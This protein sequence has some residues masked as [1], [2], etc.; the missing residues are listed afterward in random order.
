MEYALRDL[1]FFAAM[2]HYLGYAAYPRE[3][4]HA[5]WKEMLLYQFH[6]ILPGSS[7]TRVYSESLARYASLF[8]Q[9]AQMADDVRQK[10]LA[11][12]D[13]SRFKSPIIVTNTLSWDRHEW[14]NLDS[15]W[16]QMT[17]P[18]L[19]YVVFDGPPA[20]IDA[21]TLQATSTLLENELLRV[22]F[23]AN[24]SIT[25]VFDKT[26]QF[27]TLSAPANVLAVFD[28]K[29]DAW[30][31][32]FDYDEKTPQRFVLASTQAMIDGP[33]A[34][35]E[36]EYRF[37]QSTLKQTI[38][39]TLGSRR[40]DFETE[41]DWHESHKMLRTSF[42]V[43]IAVNEA[44]CNI[45]FGS[46]KRPTHSNTSWDMAR[47][48]VAAHKWVD[49]SR[50]DYGVALLND[51]KYGY[52]LRDGE[53]NL[54]LLRSPQFPDPVADHALHAF[55]Y[56]LYPHEGDHIAGKV[57]Q[58]GYELNIPVQ[59][60][61]IV[62]HPGDLP[63]QHSFITVGAEQIIVEAVKIAEHS[64]SLIVRVYEAAGAEVT[65]LLT[66]N[67]PVQTVSQTNLLEREPQ[68]ISLE[69]PV[70]FGPFDILTFQLS[71]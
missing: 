61:T 38:V 36:Q 51:C 31:C 18:A 23:A 63:E 49:L 57:M 62:A 65:T 2:A 64:D 55:T 37:G 39:L 44:T 53:L 6:D 70:M 46:I 48:E 25:S 10:L 19:G 34:R 15:G 27:E 11:H 5:I 33:Q 56:A 3:A 35:L 47:S 30:D 52:N 21:T 60:S 59:A 67:F 1:E 69:T 16:A 7:I 14:L 41:V 54:A 45:Q 22:S 9:I 8:E 58:A 50:R 29:G 68:P 20:L 42:P 4:L 32:P 12:I 40:V 66:F 43:T 24:G 71:K 26:R 13:S 28:D 17:V